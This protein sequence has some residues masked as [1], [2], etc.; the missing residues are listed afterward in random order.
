[1]AHPNAETHAVNDPG[2]GR[3]YWTQ[4]PNIVLT[5]GLSPYALALYVHL[6]KT[7]GD[8]GRCW[9]STSTLAEETEMSAG[10][11]SKAKAELEKRRQELR[12]KS[13]IIIDTDNARAGRPRHIITI[14]DIWP[15]NFNGQSSQAAPRSSPDELQTSPHEYQS[16]PCEPKK[17]PEKEKSREEKTAK[18][19]H[20]HLRA[21][22][23]P[24]ESAD[25]GVCACRT[26]HGSE[27]CDE[28][29]VA[30]ARTRPTIRDAGSYAMSK[31]VRAGRDDVL[32]REWKRE[33]NP[34]VIEQTRTAPSDNGMPYGA[35][36]NLVRSVS[37]GGGPGSD[38]VAEIERLFES[39][40][41]SEEV[42]ARLLAYDWH[43]SSSGRAA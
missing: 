1:M 35:A 37:R 34:E 43:G 2:D 42:R 6:K 26:K 18:K 19:N 25:A 29:R 39:A 16:S 12:N 3:K 20:T 33:L 4:I 7:A 10:A 22:G 31:E 27:F 38:P 23:A 9:K 36:L 11:V 40:K 30:L 17:N 41:I 5:L 28:E 32:L 13:L 14:N 15:E 21:I 24:A 8:H